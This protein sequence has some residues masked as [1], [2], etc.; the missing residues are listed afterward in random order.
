MH[1]QYLFVNPGIGFYLA[2]FASILL[3]FVQN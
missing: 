2:K 1:L 3:A